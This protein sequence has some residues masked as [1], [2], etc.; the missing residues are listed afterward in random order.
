MSDRGIDPEILRDIVYEPRWTAAAKLEMDA[1]TIATWDDDLV[2]DVRLLVPIDVQALVVGQGTG[3]PMVRLRSAV[4]DP[5]GRG[6][7]FPDPFDPGETRAAGV[8]LHWAMPD[9]LLRG[10]LT[11][12]TGANRLALPPLPDRWVVLR[13]LT[14]TGAAQAAVRGWVVEADR[15]VQVDLGAWPE[16]SAQGS[17]A[18]ALVAAEDLTGTA[19]GAATWAATYDSVE[20]RFA[21]FDPLDDI[22][23]LA[24]NGV[25]GDSATYVV[26]G[27]WSDP[28]RDPL[29]AA[30]DKGSLD[31]LLA[32]LGWSAVAPWV[33]APADQRARDE[34]T[35]LRSRVGLASRGRF[36]FT[37]AEPPPAPGITRKAVTPLTDAV[38]TELVTGA[39]AA[40]TVR[41]WWPHA[42]VLHG[43][44]YG[45][46]LAL[47]ADGGVVD[48]RPA[49]DRVQVALGA[50][51]D[52]VIGALTSGG[53]GATTPE[54]RRDTERLLGAF[55]AQRVRD[56]NGPNGAAGVE[57]HEHEIGFGS[58]PGGVRGEDRFLAGSSG[59]PRTIGRGARHEARKRSSG[60]SIRGDEKFAGVIDDARSA[61]LSRLFLD[62][63]L[64]IASRDVD[65]VVSHERGK[66]EPPISTDPRVVERPAPRFVFPLDPMIA[67]QGANR[68]L[69]HANDGRASSDGLL[70]CRWPHQV[71]QGMEG[72]LSGA[73]VLATLGNGA[74]PSE[75]LL[76]AQEAVLHSPYNRG[77]LAQRAAQHSGLP[78]GPIR[79]RLD[80]E[81]AIR[82]GKDAVYD[83]TTAAFGAR[84]LQVPDRTEVSDEIL[85]H[86]MFV[87]AEPSPIGVTMWSQPWIPLWLEWEAETELAATLDGWSLD[88]V[89]LE[90]GD[91]A[92]P[93][94]STAVRRGRTLLTTGAARTL[95]SAVRDFLAA[96]D[97]LEKSTGGAGE[98]PDDV[99][100]AL[101]D[102]A[103]AVERLDLLTAT[104]DGLRHQLLG[105]D[106]SV[107]VDGQNRT[108]D[109]GGALVPPAPIGPPLPLFAGTIRFT[110]V[111]LLDA[112]GRTLEVPAAPAAAIPVRN[113]VTGGSGILR[114]RPRLPRPARW[115][116]RLVDAA[117]VPEPAEAFVDQVDPARTVSPVAGFLL[118][119]HLDES[120][121][122]FDASGRPVGELFHEPIGQRVVWEIAPGRD[123]PP[124]AG[125]SFGLTGGQVPLGWLATGLLGADVK[126]RASAQPTF[127]T[128]L[129]AALRAIDTTLWTV[130][131]FADL[132]SEHIAGLVGRPIAVVRA[133]LW[134]DLQPEVG[135]DLSDPDRAAERLAAEQALAA[136]PIEV[137][138][139]EITRTDDGLIGFFVGDDFERLHLVD[140]VVAGMAKPS[141]PTGHRSG[142][143]EPITHP[144]VVAEDTLRIH[145]GQTLTLTLLMHPAGRVHLTSGILPRKALAL[146]RDWVAPGLAR[147][148]PSL[149]VGPVLIDT[150]QV[151]LPKPSV[152][153][154]K[155]VF[156]RR[157]TP[158]AWQD[159]PILAATQTALLPDQPAHVQDGYI[160]VAPKDP[161]APASPSA[162]AEGAT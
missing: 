159:D 75:V 56:L 65:A 94:A 93:G 102:L 51:D 83:G 34:V 92:P 37:Q 9:A 114:L 16:A 49:A 108:R 91:A 55:T 110:R 149:R 69:R 58:Y 6:P 78:Q 76:L 103:T 126:D 123:G 150:D 1:A 35:R 115:M 130:D 104:V 81:V 162:P 128:A 152:F 10:E 45:V 17:P 82:F 43:S 59:A 3:E 135:L 99:E 156:T 40:F 139:G 14:P 53:F 36:L 15:A 119:D 144:Y 20:N 154:T 95:A 4:N 117:D 133:R 28:A 90:P 62:R 84:D 23:N 60:P 132:G 73:D 120:L 107:S 47:Q 151:R 161:A 121:E 136:E 25:D 72:L 42:A 38:A 67:V 146:A 125:P 157:T 30:L 113:A 46:P 158:A 96:E 12:S 66:S 27:W 147:V 101:A 100:K 29:D 127:E 134:L 50:N 109:A 39:T 79:R 52:D 7:G 24:P 19:G 63:R 97:A 116:F 85:R 31:A 106:P 88:M 98:L 11:D 68:S 2:R 8:H 13:L 21:L 129:S 26:A 44:V 87:G 112:F 141:G 131:T 54:A 5:S 124:D 143:P 89:D 145:Y 18:G 57:E 140:Q 71:M 32:S 64:M 48:N 118:P 138:L 142:E 41:P 122:L 137:R 33:R 77:W 74:V 155:Q 80:A 160:R 153:G 111:R 105:H 86:S 148:S 22:A 70:W 61:V